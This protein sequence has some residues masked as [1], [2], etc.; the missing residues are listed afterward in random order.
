MNLQPV[1]LSLVVHAGARTY[2]TIVEVN[3]GLS[4]EQALKFR[5]EVVQEATSRGEAPSRNVGFYKMMRD[6]NNWGKTGVLCV[7]MGLG[8]AMQVIIQHVRMHSSRVGI[9]DW[10]ES[11]FG[12]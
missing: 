12:G 1:S 3:R 5:D 2:H 9:G 11:P 4:W 7:G 8:A 10:R 6:N